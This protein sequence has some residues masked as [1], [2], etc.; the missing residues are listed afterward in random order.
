MTCRS[1]RSAWPASSSVEA[2]T[3]SLP[4]LSS[5]SASRR[6]PSRLAPTWPRMSPTTTSGVRL[7][8]WMNHSSSRTG[9][10]ASMNFTAGR[11][12]PSWKIS[13]AVPEPL[14]GTVPPMSLL[15]A[16]LAQ[17]PTHS[18]W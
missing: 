3:V 6:S 11:C 4:Y 15:W 17:K 13:F 18:P 5:S 7:L 9:R 1:L 10:P 8:A 12:R 14:P 16:M 2:T